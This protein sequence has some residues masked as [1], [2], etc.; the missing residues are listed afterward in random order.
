MRIYIDESGT[1]DSNY[2]IIG[3]LFVPDHGPLHAALCRAKDEL[4]YFNKSPKRS[5]KYRETHLTKFRSSSDVAVAERWIDAFIAHSCYF[6]SMVVDWSIWDGK[7]FGG[8]FEADSLKKRRA[9]KKWAEMLISPELRN[10]E[11]EP[12]FYHAKLYLDKLK[13]LSGYDILPHLESRFTKNYHGESPYIDSFQHTDSWRDANQCLQLCD[14]LTGAI[15]QEL[16]PAR[17]EAKLKPR[18]YLA[19]RLRDFDVENLGL[20][21]WRQYIPRT[22]N[23]H[24]PKFSIRPWAPS[25]NG[26]NVKRRRGRRGKRGR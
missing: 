16:V 18:D 15:Y 7:H 26:K 25:K 22:L 19:T 2:F 5:A 23:N 13:E 21:F 3:M 8:P 9:Y 1:H 12:R 4:K 14:L 20:E 10:S 24:F 17:R 6:R 11:G